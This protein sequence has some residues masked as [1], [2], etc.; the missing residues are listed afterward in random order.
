MSRIK[1]I[2]GWSDI[3]L[4]GHVIAREDRRDRV[5]RCGGLLSAVYQMSGMSEDDADAFVNA[6]AAQDPMFT[7]LEKYIAH[8]QSQ[9]L[10]QTL[11]SEQLP[12]FD[13][14]IESKTVREWMI[15]EITSLSEA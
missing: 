9:D 14:V 1:D 6:W 10:I 7:V 11:M 12:A 4:G 13:A 2:V 8:N 3:R 5:L 15:E